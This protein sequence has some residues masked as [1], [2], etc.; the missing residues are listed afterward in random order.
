MEEVQAISKELIKP[1]S[2]TPHHL[3]HY[4]LSFLDQISVPIFMPLVLFYPREI[5]TNNKERCDLIK[6]SLSEALTH[7]YPLAGRV[8]DNMYIDCNDE[9]AHFVEA[10]A[11][12]TLSD[13]LQNPNPS[14]LNKLLPYELDH[15]NDLAAVFQ[16]T[17]F[18]CGGMA[19][20][21]GMSH[22]VGDALSFFMFLNS[23]AAIA[24]GD[25]SVSVPCFNSALL[26]PPKNIS[27][28]QPRTGIMK[29]NIVTKR[30]VFVASTIAALRAKY[31][32]DSSSKSPRR[33]TRVEALSAFI[34]SRFM[35]TTKPEAHSSD[36]I[37][38][39][40]HAVNLRPR[41][42]PPLQELYFGNISRIAVA[43]ANME[44]KENKSYGIVS[45]MR[46]AIRNVNLDYVMKLQER[47][48]HLNFMKYR[49]EKVMKGEVVSFSFTSLCRFPIYEAD[50]GWGKPVW[51]SSASLTF[52]NLVVFLDTKE[53]DGIEA[54]IN[55]KQED[56]AKFEADKELLAHV[57][58]NP[59]MKIS[60]F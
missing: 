53:E 15:V 55:L 25:N 46:D 23:W 12:C 45:Q 58:P 1:S 28:F 21:F 10:C 48:G 47:D 36:K 34:W 27:G 6:K 37:Y 2:P 22:K 41:M 7:F 31:S 38:T 39:V 19:I 5:N 43:V 32:D 24:R 44:A 17:F 51:V 42:N 30:F 11:K 4:K 54:W 50:F 3:R 9:G 57:S 40:L 49:A 14:D 59:N 18:E 56:M 52:K 33:P 60:S 35:A 13:I 16:V 8:I 26:F 20:G 29:D